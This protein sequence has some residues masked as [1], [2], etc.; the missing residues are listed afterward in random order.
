MNCETQTKTEEIDKKEFYSRVFECISYIIHKCPLLQKLF[1]K[2][3]TLSPKEKVLL[4]YLLR[5]IGDADQIDLYAPIIQGLT[6]W[7]DIQDTEGA[8]GFSGSP[9]DF[10]FSIHEERRIFQT[11]I[12]ID[13]VVTNILLRPTL[14]NEIKKLNADNSSENE[15][16]TGQGDK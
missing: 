9:Q 4:N 12:L 5:Y 10:K 7:S 15:D 2:W 14:C 11:I 13:Q 3:C 16:I 8:C 6:Y 1:L